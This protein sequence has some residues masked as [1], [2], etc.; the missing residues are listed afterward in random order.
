MQDDTPKPFRT[1]APKVTN[2][3]PRA[4]S[5]IQS[6][7]PV[8]DNYI[9]RPP[10]PKVSDPATGA[11]FERLKQAHIEY[12]KANGK[13]MP[14]PADKDLVVN[15]VVIPKEVL[16]RIGRYSIEVPPMPEHFI[17]PGEQW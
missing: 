3:I 15:G 5:V 4:D 12:C 10:E 8:G 11:A 17:R 1:I 2:T 13:V 9:P 7:R 6:N 14:I 16:R